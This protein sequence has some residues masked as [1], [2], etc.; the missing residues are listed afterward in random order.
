MGVCVIIDL[1]NWGNNFLVNCVMAEMFLQSDYF[2]QIDF[3]KYSKR[4]YLITYDGWLDY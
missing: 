2:I 4:E 1:S 3:S